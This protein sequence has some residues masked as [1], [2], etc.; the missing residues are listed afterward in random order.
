MSGNDGQPGIRLTVLS[1]P[2]LGM[3]RTFEKGRITIGRG[4]TN[5]FSLSDGFVSNF[6]GE[7][8]IE[9]ERLVYCDLK[10]RHGSLV[11]VDNVSFHLH[12]QEEETSIKITDQTEVQ[13]GCTLLK[14]ELRQPETAAQISIAEEDESALA[15][16]SMRETLITASHK[17]VPALTE[18]IDPA[19]KRLAVIFQL[20]GVLNG[21]TQLDEILERIVEAT[22]DA[23]PAANF[24][25][26][27]LLEEGVPIEDADPFMTRQRETTHENSGQEHDEAVA[28]KPIISKSIIRRVIETQESVLFVKDSL[29]SEISQSIIDAK[30]TACLCAPLVAQHSLLGIMEVDT[31]GLGSLFSRKDLDLFNIVASLAA[32]ALERAQLSSNIVEMFESFVYAS[33]NAIEARD[34]TTAGHSERVALYTLELADVVNGIEVGFAGD[35]H[36]SHDELTELRYA[37]LLHDFGKI[38]VREDVLQKALRLPE[39]HLDLIAQRFET[40]KALAYREHVEEPLVISIK[41]NEPLTTHRYE[42]L[43]NAHAAFAEKLDETFEWLR[44]AARVGFM[45]DESLERVQRLGQQAY[46]DSHGHEQPYLT[47][48]EVANLSIRRGTLND[49]EWE[50]MRSHA[51]FSENYLERIPWSS[52]LKNVP[53]IAGAH[54]EKLDGSGYPRGLT[55]ELIIPQVRMLTIADI[56]DAL[57]ASDRPYRKAASVERACS[58]LREE[59]GQHKLDTK[60]VGVFEEL[61]VPRILH[62]IPSLRQNQ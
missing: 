14:V 32:F 18:Q 22:F 57:T 16:K 35:I 2:D 30:I 54:H 10:S 37:A 20:A 24:F 40:I 56:F 23:F 12:N 50:N 44:Q 43:K 41:N 7:L 28:G 31:R 49:D 15:K 61:V 5:D 3:T 27:T 51:T 53:C 33:V 58:I 13:L 26:I 25:A 8:H 42:E 34:P 36:F 55:E 48:Y 38:A 19:D 62:H 59:A 46:V 9:P 39:L 6:H 47:P 29:G 52:Q 60:L 17:P 4:G 45:N 11:S 21:L 1:G